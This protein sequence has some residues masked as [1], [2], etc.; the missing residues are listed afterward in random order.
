MTVYSF[1]GT[2]NQVVN[3]V[4]GVDVLN[5]ETVDP[6]TIET[7]RNQ[8][9]GTSVLIQTPTGTFT[10]N[11]VIVQQLDTGDIIVN[12]GPFNTG[13]DFSNDD[14]S[15]SVVLGLSGDDTI[16]GNQ[17]NNFLQGNEGEDD[18][19]GGGG[20]DILRGGMDDDRIHNFDTGSIA[21]GDRGSDQIWARDDADG[22]TIFGGNGNPSDPLDGGDEI[23]GSNGE[24]YLQ[25]N[26][27]RDEIW[28]QNGADILR[29][30]KDN[31]I[32]HGDDFYEHE[33]DAK[34]ALQ[35]VEEH[36]HRMDVPGSDWLRGDLGDDLIDGDEEG[37]VLT[38]GTG[39]E[40]DPGG[41]HDVFAFWHKNGDLTTK[42]NGYQNVGNENI[43]YHTLHDVLAGGFGTG[44]LDTLDHITDLELG[45]DHHGG[46]VDK[47]ALS[48]W[49]AAGA[50][51]QEI[52]ISANDLKDVLDQAYASWAEIRASAGPDAATLIHVNGGNLNG[53]DFLA[54]TNDGVRLDKASVD[55]V[56]NVTGVSGDF[57][58][59]DIISTGDIDWAHFS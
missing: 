22:V 40:S 19:Y 50:V 36:P 41:D 46:A 14:L 7:V 38:G 25:G 16:T 5:M 44:Q 54:A 51:I 48:G 31:D 18:L 26:G 47:I 9:T 28:G 1:D 59:S 37:D 55:F 29:G 30:G 24:D 45:T 57:D 23:G 43:N 34:V 52:T 6:Y 11:N 32:L 42:A 10:M 4:L 33:V 8:T 13:S 3:W 27:G 12:N 53:H 58:G 39:Q 15:G 56:M 2:G 17:Y 49:D 20:M 35:A 21:Y